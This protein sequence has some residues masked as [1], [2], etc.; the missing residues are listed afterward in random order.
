MEVFR[1]PLGLTVTRNGPR[2]GLFVWKCVPFLDI[3][4]ARRFET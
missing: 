3:P 4:D 1:Y 2:N